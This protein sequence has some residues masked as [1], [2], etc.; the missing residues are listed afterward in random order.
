M[1]ETLSFFKKK[2]KYKSTCCAEDE[3]IVGSSVKLE[4]IKNVNPLSSFL[5][6]M[7]IFCV[8]IHY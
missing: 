5:T 3:G 2:Y 7:K 6:E 1:A 4:G 8:I